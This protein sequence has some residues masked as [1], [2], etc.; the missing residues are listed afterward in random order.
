MKG[1]LGYFKWFFYGDLIQTVSVAED[2]HSN[3]TGA[4]LI[5]TINCLNTETDLDRQIERL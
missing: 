3:Q 2:F 1:S 4:E 5:R